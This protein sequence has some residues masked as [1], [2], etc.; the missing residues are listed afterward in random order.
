MSQISVENQTENDVTSEYKN[1]FKFLHPSITNRINLD[2]STEWWYSGQAIPINEPLIK[3]ISDDKS[4]IEVMNY[5]LFDLTVD[6]YFE[7]PVFAAGEHKIFTFDIK[8]LEMITINTGIL[9]TDNETKLILVVEDE[10]YKKIQS[11]NV[12]WKVTIPMNCTYGTT[13]RQ[14]VTDVKNL[15]ST[16][17]NM[18]YALQSEEM[19]TILCNFEKIIGRKFRMFPEYKDDTG[20][21]TPNYTN[22]PTNM[23]EEKMCVDLS[24]EEELNKLLRIFGI[25]SIKYSG[26]QDRDTF[27]LGCCS[28]STSK[29]AAVTQGTYWPSLYNHIGRGS[30][31]KIREQF[32]KPNKAYPVHNTF[33]HEMGHLFGFWHYNSMCYGEMIDHDP[34]IICTV[35]NL[36]REELPYWDELPDYNK[37]RCGG[38]TLEKYIVENPE[39]LPKFYEVLISEREARNNEYNRVINAK[40]NLV[41]T[42]IPMIDMA[43]EQNIVNSLHPVDRQTYD[44]NSSLYVFKPL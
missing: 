37:T 24:N 23:P 32:V 22:Y 43:N 26:L 29:G 38:N 4:T 36:L 18:A 3:K 7:Y 14:T 16:T 1:P 19:K 40:K 34:N 9:D 5:S 12:C 35:V 39:F 11:I 27:S 8:P 28:N 42:G 30:I 41:P 2:P 17:T 21:G 13:K 15:L 6:V 44:M 20:A 33:I 31:I 10:R 25:N